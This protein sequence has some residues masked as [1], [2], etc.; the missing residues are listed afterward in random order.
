MHTHLNARLTALGRERLLR[1]PIDEAV[2]LA[3][4]AD[5]TAISHPTAYQ[6]VAGPLPLRRSNRISE[7]TQRPPLGAADARCTATAAGQDSA[8]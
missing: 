2:P 5:Q 6:S 4:L 3:E 7:F 1:P 8:P